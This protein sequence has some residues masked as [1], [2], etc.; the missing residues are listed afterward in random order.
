[1]A[2]SHRV[3]YRI[4]IFNENLRDKNTQRNRT[5]ALGFKQKEEEKGKRRKKDEAEKTAVLYS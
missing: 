2:V 1:M 5:I 3:G 4:L